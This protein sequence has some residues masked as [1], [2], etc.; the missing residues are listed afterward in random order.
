MDFR[1]FGKGKIFHR[2]E[3]F[4]D[5]TQVELQLSYEITLLL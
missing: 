1:I 3:L 5:D 2:Q 4:L